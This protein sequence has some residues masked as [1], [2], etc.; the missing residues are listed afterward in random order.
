MSTEMT[1]Y[2]WY[3]PCPLCSGQGRLTIFEDLTSKR[4]YLHCDECEQGWRD[5]GRV[6]DPTAGFLT[7]NEEF[8]ARPA[9]AA[10][11]ERY[12]WAKYALES[13]KSSDAR[14]RAR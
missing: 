14:R 8:E 12:G 9:D 3:K 4:L 1:T 10:T 7:L 5:P 13:Y 11:I 6:N 2:Y